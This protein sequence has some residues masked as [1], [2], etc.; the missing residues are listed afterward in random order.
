MLAE[1]LSILGYQATVCNVPERALEL[2]DEQ[3]FDLIISDF[4]MPGLNGE[5]FHRLVTQRHP[6][7]AQR[8]IFLTG[9]LVNPETSNFLKN[10]SNPHLSKPFV[11]DN[12]KAKVAEVLLN[13][14][15]PYLPETVLLN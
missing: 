10:V 9:D 15:V 2:M 5:Q 3:H 7:L 1:M 8:I 12:L 6:P 4:R 14:R 11:L 13:N